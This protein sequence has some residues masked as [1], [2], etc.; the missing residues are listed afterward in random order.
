MLLN[1]SQQWLLLM[2][3]ALFSALLYLL[4]P[5]LTPFFAAALLAYLGDPLVDRLERNKLSRSVAVIIV[6]ISLFLILALML[7]LLLPMLEQQISYLLTSVPGYIDVLQTRWLPGLVEKLGIE[8]SALN[9]DAVKTILQQH[10]K[11]AAGLAMT[12]FSSI[13][14]SG[15]VLMAWLANLVLI[16]VITFYLLRDWDI[17]LARINELLPRQYQPVVIRLAT[18]SDAV[19]AAFMRGQF[20]V[21]LA[22]AAIYTTGLWLVGLELALLIGVLA[23]LVSFVPYLGFIIGIIAA[24]IAMLLQT[25]ELSQLWL[26]LLVFGVGQMLESMLLTPWLVGDRI[27]LHPVAVI[28]AVLAGAQLFGF[29]GVLLALPVAAVLAVML[30]HAH[31]QYKASAI[32]DDGS[33]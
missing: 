33:A 26:V 21:M 18:E 12:V 4:S 13:T 17:L 11:P 29:V 3:V 8:S 32:F 27:G 20:L 15:M 19:L 9:F 23:G 5:V 10:F 7:L 22:L 2:A 31:E 24:A 14:Q 16:P 25:Q 1:D 6:F 28:F 30:R